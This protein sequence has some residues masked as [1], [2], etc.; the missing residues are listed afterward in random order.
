VKR[1]DTVN[2][3]PTPEGCELALAAAG[4]FS[5]ALAWAIDLLLRLFVWLSLA[6]ALAVVGQA[7]TGAIL[8]SGFLLEWLAPVCFEVLWHG[9]SPGKR[10][11]GLTVLHDDGT[12]VGWQASF[13]R[14]TIRFVDFL[15]VGYATG[16]VTMLINADG[17]RL[18]DLVAGT[19]V[20]HASGPTAAASPVTD[21]VEAPP[22][23]LLPDERKALVEFAQRAGALTDER[24]LELAMLPTPLVEGLNPSDARARLLRIANFL[25]GQR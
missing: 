1:L 18:G 21:G 17:K 8:L 3:R 12:P 9:Q 25:L 20:V 22:F 14:N 2:V 4:P 13:I 10:V 19:I 5:R 16:F 23:P 7:G 24:A 11:L 15:P 6:Q